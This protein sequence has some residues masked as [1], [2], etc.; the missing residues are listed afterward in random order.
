MINR[1]DSMALNIQDIIPDHQNKW[2][3]SAIDWDYHIQVIRTFAEY[4]PEYMRNYLESF[5]NL[6]NLVQSR[7]YSTTG[8]NIQ[9]NTIIPDS[10][11][12]VGEYYEDIP[13][14]VK[15]IPDSGYTFVGW[16]QY[17]DSGASMNVS[18]YEDFN[19]TAFFTSSLGC[20]LYTSP[21]PRD[22]G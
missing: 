8:G 6:S 13:I 4:R 10:Y 5:F 11:P 19:L 14:S 16:P 22:R 12:W 9:I 21:S 7:F 18:V 2:P 1:L 3:D 17:P 15:A 20:L